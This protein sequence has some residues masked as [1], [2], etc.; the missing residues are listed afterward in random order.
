MQK[1]IPFGKDFAE[2]FAAVSNAD[3]VLDTL[4]D[5]MMIAEIIFREE[6]EVLTRYCQ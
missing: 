5:Y 1:N 2:G 6:E 4:L 3:L